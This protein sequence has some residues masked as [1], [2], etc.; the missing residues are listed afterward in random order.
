ME[1]LIIGSVD[2]TAHVDVATIMLAA[3]PDGFDYETF[4]RWYVNQLALAFGNDYQEYA[5]LPGGNLGTSQQSQTLHLKSRA[6]GPRLFMKI[7]ERAMNFTGVLPRNVKFVYGDQDITE[8]MDR[9]KLATMRAEERAIRIKS[10]EIDVRVARELA[11]A[12]GDLDEE[13][14]TELE[15]ADEA[16]QAQQQEMFQRQLDA[17]QQQQQQQP[18]TNAANG[19]NDNSGGNTSKKS[20]TATGVKKPHLTETVGKT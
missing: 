16:A 11:V 15:T 17:K 4:M 6:K 13:Y 3:L 7:I 9:T 8:D 12:A 18:P 5:P 1:S 14:L 2:P 20:P 19:G 10:G